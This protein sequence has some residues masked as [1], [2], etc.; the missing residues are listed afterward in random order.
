[1]AV[2]HQKTHTTTNQEQAA[3]TDWTLEGRRDEQEVRGSA[4]PSL[5]EG[6]KQREAEK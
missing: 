1:M 3:V 5:L 4:I 6:V 2:D